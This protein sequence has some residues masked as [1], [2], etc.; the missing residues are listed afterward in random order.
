[1]AGKKRLDPESAAAL[2]VVKTELDQRKIA[3]GE[4]QLRERAIAEVFEMAGRIKATHFVK[5]QSEFFTLV[6]LKQVKDNKEYRE[7]F[8]M[9]WDQFCQHVGLKR[10]TVDENLQDLTPFRAEFLAS[11][12]N[13]LG[14]DFN[15]IKYLGQAISAESAKI[16]DGAIHY[17]GEI[18]PVTPEYAEDIQAVLETIEHNL[19]ETKAT[20]KANERLL[21]DKDR[22]K[23]TLQ[24]K[25]DKL[26]G[27]AAKQ[28]LSA[29]E[30]A[31][32]KQLANLEK[33]FEGYALQVDP[34]RMQ[35]ELA[36]ATPLMKAKLIGVLK[37]FKSQ[38]DSA[39]DTAIEMY[40]KPSDAD[41][42]WTPGAGA[43]LPADVNGGKK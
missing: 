6:A 25:L 20:L 16:E 39:Y 33:S 31:F 22:D 5:S 40:G 8:D 42:K 26:E 14:V 1:M 2:S 3:A 18:I 19:E 38:I 4:Q 11:F 29:E 36:E 34:A 21:R 17:N 7:R 12:R 27:K 43:A 32:V 41:E 35:K 28:G 10:R 9:T 37:T 13:F 15:K 30:E 23:A 24:K